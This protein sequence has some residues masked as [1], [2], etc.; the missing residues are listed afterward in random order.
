[1]TDAT[2]RALALAQPEVTE[3]AHFGKADFRVRNKIFAGFNGDGTAY[4]KLTPDQQE[5][6]CASERLVTPIAGGWG[7]QGWT[8][9]D[10]TKA[11][12]ALL[13]SLLQI[14]WRNVAPKS[15]QI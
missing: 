4:V 14:A 8:T 7:R 9:V 15:L 12:T 3:K 6:I 1:M 5:M 11:E 13:H 2:F 10:H